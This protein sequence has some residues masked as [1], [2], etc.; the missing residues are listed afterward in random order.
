VQAEAELQD[1]ALSTMSVAPAG[2]GVTWVAQVVPF[3]TSTSVTLELCRLLPLNPTAVQAVAELHDTAFSWLARAPE[4]LGIDWT[5][6]AVPFQSSAKATTL[7]LLLTN[8][9]TDVQA[10]TEV[11]DTAAST[12]AKARAGLGVRW[13]VHVLPLYTSPTT[14]GRSGT[15]SENPTA[16]HAMG[17]LHETA[18]NVLRRAPVGSGVAWTVQ[19]PPRSASTNVT[20]SP[21]LLMSSPTAVQDLDALHDTADRWNTGRTTS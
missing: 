10:V 18:V 13:I 19:L 17:D 12:L 7:P 1:T 15:P 5:A 21:E 9:P 20:W 3:H 11:H 6:H 14:T 2:F 4:A 8:S 16:T